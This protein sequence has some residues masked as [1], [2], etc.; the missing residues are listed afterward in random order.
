VAPESWNVLLN[1]LHPEAR[2]ITVAWAR[3]VAYD[4]RLFHV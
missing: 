2:L 3:R 1:A 4:R